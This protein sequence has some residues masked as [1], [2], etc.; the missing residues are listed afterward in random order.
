MGDGTDGGKADGDKK[1]V[2]KPVVSEKPVVDDAAALRT[3]LAQLKKERDDR[4]NA[5]DAAETDRKKKLKEEGD[6]KKLYED[7]QSDLSKRDAK[8]AELADDARLG[9]SARETFTRQ[10]SEGKAKLTPSQQALV[11]TLEKVDIA[12]AAALV[13][14]LSGVKPTTP[15]TPSPLPPGGAPSIDGALGFAEAWKGGEKTWKAAK[16]RDP[17]G[18]SAWLASALLGGPKKTQPLQFM[19]RKTPPTTKK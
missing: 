15:T 17:D 14:E 9:K 4:K 12:Q 5:D 16:E 13:A 10:V 3:E 11:A 1:P 18:A 8:I 2:E 19:P 7:A 6:L